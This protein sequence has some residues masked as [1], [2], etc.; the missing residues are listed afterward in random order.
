MVRHSCSVRLPRCQ[1]RM[2]SSALF[3]LQHLRS[4][5]A[6]GSQKK[7]SLTI[8]HRPIVAILPE[9]KFESEAGFMINGVRV[10]RSTSTL[11]DIVGL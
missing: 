8:D 7:K 4:D 1:A 2:L 5:I 6:T 11:H 9:A 3:E 10:T